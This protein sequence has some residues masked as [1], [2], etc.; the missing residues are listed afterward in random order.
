MKITVQQAYEDGPL[1]K[2]E[3]VQALVELDGIT[4][5]VHFDGPDYDW[6][7]GFPVE[8]NI[9]ATTCAH[10]SSEDNIIRDSGPGTLCSTCMDTRVVNPEIYQ[11]YG[12]GIDGED[13]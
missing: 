6:D 10:C 12:S 1:G 4:F 2:A 9:E 7:L 8:V 3:W 13:W 11:Q 5:S